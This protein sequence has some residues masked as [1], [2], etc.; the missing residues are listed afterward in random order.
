MLLCTRQHARVPVSVDV[1]SR[2]TTPIRTSQPLVAV[3][4]VVAAVAL[5]DVAAVAAEDDVAGRE[6]GDAGAEHRLQA[7]DQGDALGIERAAEVAGRCR[8]VRAAARSAAS[9]LEPAST[10]LN[11]V[12]DRPS[13]DSNSSSAA[14]CG[15]VGASSKTIGMDRSAFTPSGVVLVGRPVEAGHAGHLA[16]AGAAD[17]DVVAAFADELVEAAVA[18]EHVVAVDAVMGEDFVEVVAGRTV[19]GAGLDPVVALV[20]EDAFGVLVAE[21][22]VVAF[23]AEDFRAHVGAEDDEVLAVAA[24]DQ[25]EARAGMDDVVAVAGLDVVVAADVA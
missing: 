14:F 12:P 5:D 3:D 16:A 2:D 7:V 6:G 15:S 22:E 1:A 21:D 11:F 8:P 17:H 25:V 19:E 23:A 24:Q 10:S 13:T 9:S 18:E 4:D 20:A